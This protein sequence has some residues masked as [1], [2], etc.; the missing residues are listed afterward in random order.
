MHYGSIR[1]PNRA[2]ITQNYL[3]ATAE[4]YT[5]ELPNILKLDNKWTAS[6][7]LSQINSAKIY[8]G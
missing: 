4:M 1:I 3:R 6:Y 5:G 7:V 8:A 2:M